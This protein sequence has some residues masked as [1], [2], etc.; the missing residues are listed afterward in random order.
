MQLWPKEYTVLGHMLLAVGKNREAL[1]S[2]IQDTMQPRNWIPNK[3]HPP[4]KPPGIK[5]TPST[6]F[7]FH[8]LFS[9]AHHM[10]HADINRRSPNWQG[11]GHSS[12]MEFLGHSKFI[13]HWFIVSSA[14]SYKT[15][16][17]SSWQVNSIIGSTYLK[18]KAFP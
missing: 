8:V 15:I 17:N 12:S 5:D 4:K 3:L 2:I 16:R 10:K 13:S 14:S 9:W 7:H 11:S 1:C 18:P 6:L